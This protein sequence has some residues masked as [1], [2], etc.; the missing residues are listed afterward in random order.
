MGKVPKF[1]D[2]H[3]TDYTI[4]RSAY[5]EWRRLLVQVHDYSI[6]VWQQAEDASDFSEDMLQKWREIIDGL[7]LVLP[8]SGTD[9]DIR[10]IEEAIREG[11]PM[12]KRPNSHHSGGL[13]NAKLH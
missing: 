6:S 5:E 13:K 11:N 4:P 8:R 10:R 2:T 12:L 3:F 1:I 7:M 9:I